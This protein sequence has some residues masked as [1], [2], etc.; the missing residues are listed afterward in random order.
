MKDILDKALED[1]DE[2]GHLLMTKYKKNSKKV[3]IIVEGYDDEIYYTNFLQDYLPDDWEYEFIKPNKST[4][5]CSS[6]KK[7][8]RCYANIDWR[9]YNKT[10]ILFFIDRDLSDFINE[11]LPTQSNFYITDGYSIEN[12]IINEN[13][14]SRVMT[15][16]CYFDGCSDEDKKYLKKL[17]N[18]CFKF[19]YNTMANVM[20]WIIY[21]QLNGQNPQLG[22]IQMKKI[23]KFDINENCSLKD[24]IDNEYFH[25]KFKIPYNETVK[26][27]KY[28]N[29]FK[30]FD[31]N[32][33]LIRGKYLLEFFIEFCLFINSQYV[34]IKCL[35]I[36]KRNNKAT[37]PKLSF[38]DL[39]HIAKKPKS[40]ALFLE[41]N[42]N[43]YVSKFDTI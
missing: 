37:M 25:N 19:F 8:L 13:I 29:N 34:N 32:K 27:D 5:N 21:W 12:N 31:K 1:V 2:L 15:E 33:M 41:N 17:Y 42:I 28:V 14:L 38:I 36:T 16:L 6:K 11:H 7:I 18:N 4:T 43:Q 20:G 26:I 35:N 24:N 23:F 3:Y 9:I 10:Q 39:A 30:N 22:N 40:L